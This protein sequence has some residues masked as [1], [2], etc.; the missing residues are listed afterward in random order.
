MGR[1]S[2]SRGGAEREGDRGSEAG[3]ALTAAGL[4]QGSNSRTVGSWPEL[5]IKSWML[6]RLSYPGTHTLVSFNACLGSGT[7]EV[8][9]LG[10]WNWTPCQKLRSRKGQNHFK[11]LANSPMKKY[12]LLLRRGKG[13]LCWGIGRKAISTPSVILFLW[14]KAH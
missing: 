13:E 4:I 9:H 12:N 6:N 11:T 1:E 10:N 2:T 3:S 7:I 14:N 8:G 5:E